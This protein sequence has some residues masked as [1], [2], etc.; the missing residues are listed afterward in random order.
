[1]SQSSSTP[2]SNSKKVDYVVAHKW[3]EAKPVPGNLALYMYGMGEIHHGTLEEA[4]QF[5]LY[6]RDMKPNENWD[7]YKVKFEKLTVIDK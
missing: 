2:R 5:L 7:L 4:R 3:D 1:M 6:V